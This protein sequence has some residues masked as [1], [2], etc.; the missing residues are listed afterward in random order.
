MSDVIRR[1]GE[2]AARRILARQDLAADITE[3]VTA[4]LTALGGD[5]TAVAAS[6][7]AAGITGVR[8]SVDRCPI[9]NFLKQADLGD[10]LLVYVSP[11]A[12][13]ILPPGTREVF[14]VKTTGAVEDFISDFDLGHFPDLSTGINETWQDY[15]EGG[16]QR[17]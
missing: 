16:E 8:Y 14:E 5:K 1:S 15:I 13:G 3:R 11:I 6:L 17:G 9:T 7:H 10:N 4:K 12:V 2:R